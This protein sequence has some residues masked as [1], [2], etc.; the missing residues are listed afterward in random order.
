MSEEQYKEGVRRVHEYIAAGDIYQVNL[1]QCYRAEAQWRF[2]VFTLPI[3]S[4]GDAS[5]ISRLDEAQ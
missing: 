2:F 1:T 4:R 5:A 3:S